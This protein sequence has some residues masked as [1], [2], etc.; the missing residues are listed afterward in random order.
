MLLSS[1]QLGLG[2]DSSLIWTNN[3]AHQ[4]NARNNTFESLI[5]PKQGKI[6]IPTDFYKTWKYELHNH[7]NASLC[8]PEKQ[9]IV[10]LSLAEDESFM[11]YGQEVAAFFGLNKPTRI[12]LDY[13]I[14][15]NKFGMNFLP[16]VENVKT[17]PEKQVINIVSSEDESDRHTEILPTESS[18]QESDFDTETFPN[19]IS[20]NV[21]RNTD[22]VVLLSDDTNFIYQCKIHT[23]ARS[24]D[25]GSYE[26]H[27]GDG[28][29]AYMRR[30]RPRV[31]DIIEFNLTEPHFELNVKLERR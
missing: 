6:L 17:I 22:Q 30:H 24:K 8:I 14:V 5:D 4:N 23:S 26:K 9:K 19:H 7:K 20:R 25:Y 12:L 29:Y 2:L 18:Q 13:Q 3:V 31:D 10:R 1:L 15:E 11:Y 28:W 21:L 27:I 16:S